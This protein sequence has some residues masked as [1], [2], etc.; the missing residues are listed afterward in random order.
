[1]STERTGQVGR[2]LRDPFD[3]D[4]AERLVQTVLE[5]HEAGEST[6]A[7]AAWVFGIRGGLAFAA[8]A[9]V[10]LIVA[11]ALWLRPGNEPAGP[12]RLDS[13]EVLTAVANRQG[14]EQRL[15][16]L[17]DDSSLEL[18]PGTSLRAVGNTGERLDLEQSQGRAV[19]R[20][21]PG[22]PRRW[23]IDAGLATVEVVGTVFQIDRRPERLIVSVE[24]GRVRVESA[25]LE[26]GAQVLNAGDRLELNEPEP[27]RAPDNDI[28]SE[29]A[30][31]APTLEPR[32]QLD[33][34][35]SRA[36][37]SRWRQLAVDGDFQGAWDMLG[38]SGL[39]RETGEARTMAE[40]LELADVARRSG[41]PNE[42]VAP[43]ERSIEDY[44][45]DRRAAVAAF[46]LGRVEADALG[47]HGAA[48][49]AFQRC[50]ELDPPEA[51]RETAYARLAEA[52]AAAGNYAGARAAA[53]E[54]LRRY[55]EGRHA[56]ELSRWVE[57]GL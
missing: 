38:E 12:L 8:A 49:R 44:P 51:L 46:T 21:Q 28:E 7:K 37:S 41:H 32:P 34:G 5:R 22:G 36:G 23:R 16:R 9:A 14:T 57:P 50:L 56:E 43:L 2:L 27:T 26:S 1:M 30:L 24:R 31:E 42:A 11:V 55:P 48:A 13:R 4:R 53:R 29:Q 10:V 39:R 45:R 19:F 15:F 47:R 35:S 6:P 18:W 54:Y 40:L 20:V 17:E 3:D 33:G 52:H 25:L